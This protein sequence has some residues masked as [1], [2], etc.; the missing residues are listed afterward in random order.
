MIQIKA[1]ITKIKLG[2]IMHKNIIKKATLIITIL[3]ATVFGQVLFEEN[4]SYP[5]NELLTNHGWTAHSAPGTNSIRVYTPGLT[6]AGYAGS[7]IGNAAK[8]DTS[9]EDVNDTFALQTSGTVYA[10]FMVNIEKATTTGDYFFHL[11]SNPLSTYYF[12]GRVYAKND[13]SGNIAFG[14]TKMNETPVTYTSYSYSLNITYLIVLKCDIIAGDSN[15]IFSLFIFDSG[16]PSG[17]PGTPAIGPYTYTNKADASDIG[18]VA[19]RQGSAASAPRV[20]IDGIL[21]KTTWDFTGTGIEEN[22]LPSTQNLLTLNISPNPFASATNISFNIAPQNLRSIKIYDAT[23]NLVRV[24]TDTKSNMVIWDG[25]DKTDNI[26]APGVYF[27]QAE[28]DKERKI[29]KVTLLR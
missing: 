29:S 7:G 1:I 4:F 24:L 5:A 28:T 12:T 17:E 20:I 16:V 22:G 26:V 19:L 3:T 9:G 15:D 27:I 2:G 25:H 6:Y 21:I 23:G 10:A 11:S 8:V 18:S 14:L 13:G